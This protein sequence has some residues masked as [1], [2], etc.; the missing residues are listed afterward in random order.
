MVSPPALMVVAPLKELT[1]LK[2]IVF[3]PDTVSEPVPLMAPA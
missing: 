1:P 2:V 3:G